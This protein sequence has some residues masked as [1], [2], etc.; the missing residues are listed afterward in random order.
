MALVRGLNLSLNILRINAKESLPQV[1]SGLE[2][3]L[4][5]VQAVSPQFQLFLD[6]AFEAFWSHFVRIGTRRILSGLGSGIPYHSWAVYVWRLCDSELSMAMRT[7][8]HR[9]YAYANF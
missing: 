4:P 3:M 1:L 7:I 2:N 8:Y 9:G 5:G 6:L